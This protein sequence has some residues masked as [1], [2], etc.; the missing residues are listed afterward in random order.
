MSGVHTL[1]DLMGLLSRYPALTEKE[2]EAARI[3][4]L[5]VERALPKGRVWPV[6]TEDTDPALWQLDSIAQDMTEITDSLALIEDRLTEI[7][8]QRTARSGT[9]VKS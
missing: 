6:L 5:G 4:G 8:R 9:Q 2:Q 3:L 1:K 7:K